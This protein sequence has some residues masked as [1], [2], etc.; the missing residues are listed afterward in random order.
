MSDAWY[1]E[2]KAVICEQQTQPIWTAEDQVPR[3]QFGAAVW[4]EG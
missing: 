1:Q 3:P 2:L 4:S